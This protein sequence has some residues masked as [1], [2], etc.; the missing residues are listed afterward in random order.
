[1]KERRIKVGKGD[2]AGKTNAVLQRA[3]DEA[4]AA[5]GGTVEL[6]AGTFEMHDSLH[7]KSHVRVVGQGARTVL[8]K[9]PCVRSPIVDYLG[10]GHYEVTVA[11]PGLFRPGTGVLVRDDTRAGFDMTVATV[12][13]VIG[14]RVIIDKPLN[15]DYHPDKNARLAS[16]FPLVVAEFMEDVAVSDLVLDG[17]NDTEIMG[18]CRGGGVF[19]LQTH[20]ATVERLEIKDYNG[21]GVSFQQCTDVVVRECHVHD[22]VENGLHPGSGSVRYLVV[23]NDVHDCGG[24]GIFYC[25]RT[26]HSLCAGNRVVGSGRAGISIGERDSDHIVRGNEIRGNAW[27]GVVFRDVHAHGGDRVVLEANTF[28]GNCLKQGDAEVFIASR[29]EG[30]ELRGNEFA[31]PSVPPVKVEA[32]AKGVYLIGNT[33]DGRALSAQDVE[34]ESGNAVF[35]EPD[36]PLEVGP[37]AAGADLA[38]HL[39]M[40]LPER[41]ANFDL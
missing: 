16:V 18:G 36:E 17:A 8:R 25:L 27:R 5:G 40:D 29:I 15:Y 11:D 21:D 41:P 12:T 13:A 34:D 38:L 31:G 14:N 23:D 22:L 4:A 37:A 28:A 7:L 35:G 30:V 33:V 3:V 1:M 10:Y 39:G 6:P 19:L 2:Y 20:T 24:T 26:T 9:V 32:E